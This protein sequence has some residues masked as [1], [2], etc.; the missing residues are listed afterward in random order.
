MDGWMDAGV[1]EIRF[2]GRVGGR[3]LF[4]FCS[5]SSASSAAAASEERVVVVVVVDVVDYV[6]VFP[7]SFLFLIPLT[8]LIPPQP[9]LMFDASLYF[10]VSLIPPDVLLFFGG[11]N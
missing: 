10:L 3:H 1:V 2:G 9:S 6:C 5:C 8:F 11:G 7:P 4:F